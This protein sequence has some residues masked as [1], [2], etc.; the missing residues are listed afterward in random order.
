MILEQPEWAWF[1]VVCAAVAALRLLA[2]HW[3]PLRLLSVTTAATAGF[4]LFLAVP[5]LGHAGEFAI[6]VGRYSGLVCAAYAAF[7]AGAG[8]AR[9]AIGPVRPVET[10]APPSPRMVRAATWFCA[11]WAAARVAWFFATGGLARMLEVTFGGTA[12]VQLVISRADYAAETVAQTLAALLDRGLGYLFVGLWVLM[13]LRRPRWALLA[14]A[15][16]AFSQL[17]VYHSRSEI[18]GLAVVPLCA[19]LAF[20]RRPAR[21]PVL[22]LGGLVA[23]ALVFFSW[24]AAVRLGKEYE[25]TAGRVAADAL[26]DAG[27]SGAAATQI[28]H[29]GL[30]GS[31]A[32]YARAMAGFFVPRAVWP[33]KPNLQYNIE[34]TELLTGLRV[35]RDTSIVTT[36]M[37][38]EAWFYGGVGGTI[39]LL[40]LFGATAY[41]AERVLGGSAIELAGL[42]FATLFQT[43]I[44]VRSTFLTYY[45]SA[46]IM[47]VFGWLWLAWK[48]LCRTPHP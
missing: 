47:I 15:G 46:A 43:L 4:L 26:R 12:H 10:L 20:R 32:D 6:P 18:L 21:R 39:W 36:T 27:S 16:F 8:L 38:G 33:A 3:L 31:P 19:Y 37:L 35:G 41:L 29:A 40:L 17:D 34:M 42:F 11:A 24:N 14:W 5:L 30:R 45:Q 7:L 1:G 44:M 22:L 25:L 13:F 9:V 2:A 48:R 28:L 23:G